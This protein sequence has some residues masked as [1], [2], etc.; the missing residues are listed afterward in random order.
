MTFSQSDLFALRENE[1]LRL[2]ELITFLLFSLV[3]GNPTFSDTVDSLTI[4]QSAS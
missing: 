2:L 1:N 3:F 4:D